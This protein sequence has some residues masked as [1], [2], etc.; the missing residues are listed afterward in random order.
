MGTALPYKLKSPAS[1]VGLLV[2]LVELLRSQASFTEFAVPLHE[3]RDVVYMH[4]HGMVVF[5]AASKP[6]PSAEA[7]PAFDTAIDIPRPV[8]ALLAHFVAR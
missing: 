6:Q 5:G 8:L 1:A 2:G 3:N 7:G 4:A